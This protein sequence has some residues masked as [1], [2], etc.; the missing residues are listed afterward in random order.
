MDSINDQIQNQLYCKLIS[1][2][3]AHFEYSG[4]FFNKEHMK[5]ID[6]GD[7][8]KGIYMYVYRYTATLYIYGSIYKYGHTH[9]CIYIYIRYRRS[10]G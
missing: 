3:S 4:C 1:M 5:R 9:I 10:D 6:P 7:S 2:N 8:A